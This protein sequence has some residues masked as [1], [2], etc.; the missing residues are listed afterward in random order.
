VIDF[1]FP[2]LGRWKYWNYIIYKKK[3]LFR[4][5]LRLRNPAQWKCGLQLHGAAPYGEQINGLIYWY[6]HSGVQSS[7]SL[8]P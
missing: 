7:E 8:I 4:G 2:T 1:I 5:Q 6:R 3:E